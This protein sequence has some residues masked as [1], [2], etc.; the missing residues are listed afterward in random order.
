MDN[1]GSIS[2][3]IKSEFQRRC[4]TVPWGHF[5]SIIR[6]HLIFRDEEASEPTPA[7]LRDELDRIVEWAFSQKE[8][9][10]GVSDGADDLLSI[11]ELKA[12]QFRG[13]G[14]L[15]SLYAEMEKL[16]PLAEMARREVES[17]VKV[18]RNLA[19]RTKLALQLA[20]MINESGLAVT[21]RKGGPLAISYSLAL[22]AL[23]EEDPAPH[24]T[25]NA[26]LA[27]FC[28]D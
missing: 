12:G 1:A 8:F 14:I 2:P 3:R 18:G 13:S 24:K 17:A 22:E 6:T 26:A 10:R 27:L 5:S 11:Q 19:L 9:L 15:R 20:R 23:G 7:Q 28:D 16:W 25:L 4:E 21:V